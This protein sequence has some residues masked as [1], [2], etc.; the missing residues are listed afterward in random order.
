MLFDLF[1]VFVFSSGSLRNKKVNNFWHTTYNEKLWYGVHYI[2][3]N[4]LTKSDEK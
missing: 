3:H 1:I 4:E 2:K